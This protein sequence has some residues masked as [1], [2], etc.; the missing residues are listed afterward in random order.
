MALQLRNVTKNLFNPALN[1]VRHRSRSFL[2]S[3][4]WDDP[5]R[6]NRNLTSDIW[7]SDPFDW[8]LPRLS[9][10]RAPYW[11]GEKFLSTPED[12]F[13]VSLNVQNFKPEEVT[14]K[15]AEN[16]VIIEAKHEER[17]EDD[18]YVSRHFSRRYA[19]PDSCS[20]KDI[21]ST[22]SSDGILTIR[23]PPK[24]IDQANARKIHIQHTG[25][26]HIEPETPK[27]TEENQSNKSSDSE[28]SKN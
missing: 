4:F 7:N 11:E 17:N 14:V 18:S 16:N 12:G 5:F 6:R 22:L 9:A 2:P 25:T 24:E 15:V 28:T 1:L 10:F 8:A 21:V 3:V 23:A 13:Q 27:K 20:I 26:A 19:I